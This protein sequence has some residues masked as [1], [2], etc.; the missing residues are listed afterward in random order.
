MTN[1]DNL[2]FVTFLLKCVFP[3]FNISNIEIEPYDVAQDKNLKK[4]LKKY[5]K[6]DGNISIISPELYYKHVNE[7]HPIVDV[8]I[9]L[10]NGDHFIIEMQSSVLQHDTVHS[11]LNFIYRTASYLARMHAIQETPK[12]DKDV[13]FTNFNKVF[14]IILCNYDLFP[15][16]DI[17][18]TDLTFRSPQRK[19]LEV[20]LMF[21]SF[22]ELQ[23]LK[24]QLA[25][26]KF[27]QL[28]D[29]EAGLLFFSCKNDPKY[30]KVLNFLVKNWEVIKMTN[31]LFDDI[32]ATKGEAIRK[33]QLEI[34]RLDAQMISNAREAA[35]VKAAEQKTEAALR[36]KEA[37][38]REK[39]AAEREKE[40][41]LREKEA[42]EQKTEA[43]LRENEKLRKKLARFH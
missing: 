17:I 15:G 14:G 8:N 19:D 16:D 41:A 4:I 9:R 37:A 38:L 2:E 3:S 27:K 1:P 36:E 40:A 25:N 42:A 32:S 5:K 18:R 31:Q 6:K 35:A 29:L 21:A 10:N 7:Y 20:D 24:S 34:A 28:T 43:V 26:K 23:K 22:F 13:I 12:K 30:I 39:E 11:N 33:V